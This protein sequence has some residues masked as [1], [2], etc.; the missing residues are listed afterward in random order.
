MLLWGAH[1]NIQKITSTSWSFYVL[2]YAMKCEPPGKLNLDIEAAKRL[3]L[4]GVSNAQ[5]KAISA[6]TMS[7]PVSSTSA[8]TA[9]LGIES[10]IRSE[11]VH[12]VASA[13]PN[14]RLRMVSKRSSLFVPPVDRYCARPASLEG[15]TFTHYFKHYQVEKQP[16]KSKQLVGRDALGHYVYESERVVHFTDYHPSHHTEGYFYNV[17]LDKIPFRVENDLLSPN[18]HMGFYL[19]ECR[20]R[21]FV[22][23]EADLEDHVAD[24]AQ[25][26]LWREEQRQQLVDLI[27]QQNLIDH[28]PLESPESE[29][30]NSDFTGDLNSG[31]QQI[32]TD[33]GLADEFSHMHTAELTPDQQDAFNR[34]F[35]AKG[36]HLL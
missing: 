23:S 32:I 6:L 25:R 34:I 29:S 1:C 33:L 17:L 21:G 8:A 10:I 19:L 30:L 13:P 35:E 20:L 31:G 9:M 16:R 24:Y 14:L 5:L 11:A 12:K 7:Q 3:G 4:A 36:L 27:L 26:H 18:N 28:L 2:K 15:A 22:N